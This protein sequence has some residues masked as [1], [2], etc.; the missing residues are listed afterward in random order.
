MHSVFSDGTWTPEELVAEG[1]RLKLGAMA[2]T[3]HDTV[4]GFAP[5]VRASREQGDMRILSGLELDSDFSPGAMHFLGYG[6]D[7]ES[8]ILMEHLDWLRG[9]TEA[10]NMDIMSKL[11]GL[12][13]KIS[14]EDVLGSVEISE[15][16]RIH[17]ASAIKRAGYVKNK[18]EAF[19]QYLSEGRPAYSPKRKLTPLACIDLI[20]ESGGV[21]VIAHPFTVKLKKKEMPHMVWELADY[22]L[23]GL[24]VYYTQSQ[25][26]L[27]HQFLKIIKST[28]LIATGGS[29]F[30][31]AVTPDVVVGKGS[32]N[33]KVPNELLDPLLDRIGDNPKSFLK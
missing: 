10:R 4:D 2:L 22:G 16:R 29:D 19:S 21:P 5:M 17:F 18:H 28:G 13:M 30:H 31:G 8:D 14:W 3:D 24:E 7:P 9:G 12:G 15:V 11:Q 33:L 25:P 6:V 27:E 1:Y 32:G 26:G 23:G 20:I